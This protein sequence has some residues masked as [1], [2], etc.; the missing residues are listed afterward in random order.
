LK[1]IGIVGFKRSGKT[2]LGV[3]LAREL[4]G[5]GHRIAVLK[6][7]SSDIA[8]PETDT[9]KYRP[10]APWIAAIAPGVTEILL[11]GTRKLA[12]VLATC[13]AD[14]VLVE[15]FKR[16][17]TLPK[18]VCLRDAADKTKLFD[19]LQLFTA[20]LQ[21]GVADVHI[22]NDDD[23]KRI[24]PILME[25]GFALPALDCGLCG[26]ENCYALAKAIVAGTASWE[27]CLERLPTLRIICGGERLA[28]EAGT[29]VDLRSRIMAVLSSLKERPQ[30]AIEIEIPE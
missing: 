12:D 15:G 24:A 25:R 16:E 1:A 3:R 26:H 14:F 4:S 30:G 6:H 27:Q 9:S 5:R 22:L 2:T 10:Y 20:G 7:A 17:K 8:L 23:I 21:P 19:G 28:L 13:D 29:A 18:I 11:A